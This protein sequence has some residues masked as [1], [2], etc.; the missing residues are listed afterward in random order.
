VAGLFLRPLQG[1]DRRGI[2]FLQEQEI[3]AVIDDDDSDADVAFFGFGFGAGDHGLNGGEVEI[4]FD[5]QV[6]AKR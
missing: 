6:V 3:A 1:V 5:R 2:A 4:F